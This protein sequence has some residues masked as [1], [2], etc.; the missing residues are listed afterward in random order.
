[1]LAGFAAIILVIVI[2]VIAL[3]S[4]VNNA[5]NPNHAAPVTSAPAASAPAS[6][7]ASATPSGPAMLAPG[8]S[9]QIADSSNATIGTV[10]VK[11]ITVTTNPADP[12][13]GSR[14]ANGYFV[15]VKLS[16]SADPSYTQG[17]DINSLDFYALSHGQQYQEGNGNSFDALN[18]NQSNQDITATLGAG[19]TASGWISFDVARPH[20]TIVYAPNSDGQPISEWQY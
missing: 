10:T 4:A 20:G 6:A 7:A 1:L 11:S 19:Q 5:A 12:S 16:A 2:A 14:P 13:F 15:I 9:E 3:G 17:Y 18:N 8:Q